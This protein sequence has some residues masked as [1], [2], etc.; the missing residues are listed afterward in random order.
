MIR[1]NKTVLAT[2]VAVAFTLSVASLKAERSDVGGADGL[3]VPEG[4]AELKE[5][6]VPAHRKTV[7]AILERLE[8]KPEPAKRGI[9]PGSKRNQVHRARL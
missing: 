9:K 7:K 3:T 5:H 2:L 4:Q 8:R 1:I 6:G